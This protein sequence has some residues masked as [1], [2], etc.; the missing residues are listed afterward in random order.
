MS[1]SPFSGLGGEIYESQIGN[2]EVESWGLHQMMNFNVQIL[3]L[4]NQKITIIPPGVGSS[5][6]NIIVS[7]CACSYLFSFNNYHFVVVNLVD[8][9][10]VG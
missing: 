8:S 4:W 10:I 7:V 5:P 6:P 1:R 2:I 3:P 9:M